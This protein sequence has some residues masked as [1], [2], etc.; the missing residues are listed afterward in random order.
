ILQKVADAVRPGISTG[1]LN[2]LAEKL[3]T[4]GGDTMPF[5]GYRPEGAP[6]PYP[7]ALCVSV[8]DEV[9][10]GIP[11]DRVLRGGDI[12]S[13]DMGLAHDG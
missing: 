3:I 7:A 12:V 4:E 9:V 10:H 6:Y 1:E 8:N 11:G 5:K 13:L 2:A